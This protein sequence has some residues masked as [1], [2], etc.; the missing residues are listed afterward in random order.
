MVEENLFR[1]LEKSISASLDLQSTSSEE[2]VMKVSK[3]FELVRAD[4]KNSSIESY[5]ESAS[6][7]LFAVRANIK[8]FEERN[9]K[10]WKPAFDHLEMIWQIAQE[11]GEAHGKDVQERNGNDNNTTMAALAHIFP[12]SLLVVQEIICLLKGGFPDGALSRWRSLHEFS[13]TARYIAQHGEKAATE[14]LLSF[15]FSARNA[16]LQIN[17]YSGLT[18]ISGFTET[19]IHELD[20]RCASA[21]RILGRTI[22]TAKDGE[23]PKITVTHPNFASVEKSVNMD[24]W[25]PWYKWA[26]RYTHADH[27]P[28]HDS[29]GLT[30]TALHINLIGPSNSGFVD[31]FQLTA[32]TLAQLVETYLK[33]SINLD[34]IVHIDVFH[35]LANQMAEIALAAERYTTQKNK[36]GSD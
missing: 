22:K 20:A 21:E 23:W 17:K 35:E 5:E 31:P 6:E 34:R 7:N 32:L 24:H 12:K 19:D 30:E 11:L 14:Y 18:G 2:A 8:D 1:I 36:R 28:A 25:R 9:F 26:S 15:H 10:R 4:C 33:H 3:L 29:L 16:A 13:L 27:R